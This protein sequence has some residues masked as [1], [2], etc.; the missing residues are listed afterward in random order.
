MNENDTTIAE[1]RSIAIIAYLTLIGLIIAFVWNAEKKNKFAHFHIL[2]STGIMGAGLAIG[3]ISWVPF[4]GWVIA[5]AGSLILLVL[6]ISG[7]MNAANGKEKPVPVLGEYF[8]RW[9]AGI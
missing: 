5:V 6:W 4:I 2:Q 8:R 7:L 3:F 9:L 1:G